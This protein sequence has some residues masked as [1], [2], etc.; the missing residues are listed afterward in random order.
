VSALD[1]L[2]SMVKSKRITP[3]GCVIMGPGASRSRGLDRTHARRN[4]KKVV[5]WERREVVRLYLSEKL[6]MNAIAAE[7]CM[8]DASVRE[9]LRGNGVEL[10]EGVTVDAAGVCKQ[11]RGTE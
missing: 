11:R 6:S 8:T 9:I 1:F 4:L 2:D 7:M 5:A 3:S 10:R